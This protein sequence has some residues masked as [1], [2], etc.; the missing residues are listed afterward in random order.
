M[1]FSK[2]INTNLLK[3][4][5]SVSNKFEIETYLVGGVIRDYILYS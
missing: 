5:R 3:A 1:D 2:L 4:I